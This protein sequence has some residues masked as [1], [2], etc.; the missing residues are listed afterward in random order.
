M[1][2]LMLGALVAPAWVSAQ[3][4]DASPVVIE[5]VPVETVEATEPSGEETIE[6]TEPVVEATEEPTDPTAT[7]TPTEQVVSAAFALGF[8][9]LTPDPGTLPASGST[10]WTATFGGGWGFEWPKDLGVDLI[11]SW[12]ATPSGTSCSG[13]PGTGCSGAAAIS[14]TTTVTQRYTTSVLFGG[15]LSVTIPNPTET[16]LYTVTA[17]V[18]RWSNPGGSDGSDTSTFSVTAPTAT[19]TET[20]TN[21]PT[22]TPTNTPTNTPTETPTNTP[23]NTPTETPTNTPTNTPTETATATVTPTG[24]LDPTETPTATATATATATVTS[25]VPPTAT[26]SPT[27]Q[28]D[29]TKVPATPTPTVKIATLPNTGNGSD[30][31]GAGLTS[32]ALLLTAASGILLAGAWDLRR[33]RRLG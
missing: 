12:A 23:T 19:P 17:R 22:E 8:I 28:P 24:T 26:A 2:S 3:D 30:A 16:G 14:G 7:A 31:G 1:V 21:T 10:T 27:H 4:T 6:A 9:T 15:S 29:P 13:I 32:S 25:T 5:T 18:Y 20:P 11:F 33:R